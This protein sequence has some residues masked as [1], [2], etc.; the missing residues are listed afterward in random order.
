MLISCEVS[1][2]DAWKASAH[3]TNIRVWEEKIGFAFWNE[4]KNCVYKKCSQMAMNAKRVTWDWIEFWSG[5]QTWYYIAEWPSE[6]FIEFKKIIFW[7]LEFLKIKKTLKKFKFIIFSRFFK[8]YI[9]RHFSYWDYPSWMIN[10]YSYQSLCKYYH[11][12]SLFQCCIIH[13]SDYLR[14]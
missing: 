14:K 7:P 13:P 9:F 5:R 12:E 3:C 6:I 1:V 4:K 11:S 10:N 8:K 2:N